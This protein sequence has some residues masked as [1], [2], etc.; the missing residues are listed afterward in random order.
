MESS[1]S[2]TKSDQDTSL[3]ESTTL[4]EDKKSREVQVNPEEASGVSESVRLTEEML[5]YYHQKVKEMPSH[6]KKYEEA[7]FRV[8]GTIPN[9]VDPQKFREK[10]KSLHNEEKKN[11]L[12]LDVRSFSGKFLN[13]MKHQDKYKA[14]LSSPRATMENSPS[15]SDKSKSSALEED[16]KSKGLRVN[17]EEVIDALAVIRLTEEILEYYYQKDKEKQSCKRRYGEA[18]YWVYGTIPWGVDPRKFKKK[19]KHLQGE[20]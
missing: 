8:Y 2:I 17:P 3:N 19:M 6:K 1:S 10:M 7:A 12:I 20:K 9:G 4:E 18:A 13:T 15:K 11:S 14:K 16:Q 5:E